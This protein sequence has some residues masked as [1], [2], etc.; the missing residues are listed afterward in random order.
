[1]EMYT[2]TCDKGFELPVIFDDQDL[3]AKA[4]KHLHDCDYK[5]AAVYTRSAFEK[6]IRKYC[7]KKGKKLV[8][9]SH[10]K[11]YSSQN[12]W[13]AIKADVPGSINDIERY[14]ALVLNT[15]S[16]YNTDRHEIKI[17]LKNAIKA[18]KELDTNLK[19][20]S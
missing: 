5:A 10:L 3:I 15:F 18:V 14:R 13:K 4:D 16:H 17:E 6:M 11:D 9:K 7:E 2:Q 19:A 20:L 12:F 8:F 1:M